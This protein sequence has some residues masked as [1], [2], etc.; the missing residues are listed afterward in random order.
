MPSV[1]AQLIRV[2]VL[3]ELHENYSAMWLLVVIWQ[4][5]CDMPHLMV[6]Y[7][8]LISQREASHLSVQAGAYSVQLFAIVPELRPVPISSIVI[9]T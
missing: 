7:K 8:A 2:L 5:D 3:N 9:R 1:A 6:F 4:A